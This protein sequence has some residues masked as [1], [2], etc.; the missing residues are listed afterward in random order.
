MLAH[1]DLS[2]ALEEMNVSRNS[3]WISTIT[4]TTKVPWYFE[5]RYDGIVRLKFTDHC[6]RTDLSAD[7]MTA[8]GGGGLCS[9]PC[10]VSM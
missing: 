8:M 1:R 9:R 6:R 4:L 3:V 2:Q 10:N 5:A 7:L